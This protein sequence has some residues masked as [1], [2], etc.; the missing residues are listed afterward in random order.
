MEYK[1]TLSR[2]TFHPGAY[3][4][5][6]VNAGTITHGFVVTGPG[7]NHTA[8]EQDPGGSETFTVTLQAGSYEIYCPVD[9]HRSLGMD[10]HI[11]VS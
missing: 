5:K 9:S 11:T 7:V 10:V 4:F 6:V 3:T 2:S 8:P 1:I